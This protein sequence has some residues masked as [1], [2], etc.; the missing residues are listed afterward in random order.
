MA[1]KN[2]A[3]AYHTTYVAMCVALL[4]VCSWISIPLAVHLT[5]Q[6]FAVFFIAAVSDWKRSC[7]AMLLYLLLGLLGLPLFSGFQAGP[8]V[9]FHTTGGYLWG[10]ALAAPIISLSV[11]RFGNTLPVLLLSMLLSLLLCY[12]LGTAWFYHLYLHNGHNISL[13]GALG[14]CV[15]PFILPD[16]LKIALAIILAKRI[17]PYLARLERS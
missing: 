12:T 4:T 9:L 6:S 16:L 7:S 1:I 14:I 10:F 13:L 15:F 2:R 5:L 8:S 3:I 17:S 11:K